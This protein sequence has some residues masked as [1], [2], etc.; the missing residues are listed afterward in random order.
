MVVLCMCVLILNLKQFTNHF[1]GLGKAIHGICLY[2][3]IKTVNADVSE[4]TMKRTVAVL[5]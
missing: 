4:T 2:V 5:T 1:S 3:R